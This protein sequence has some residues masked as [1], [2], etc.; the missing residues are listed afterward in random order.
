MNLPSPLSHAGT[1]EKSALWRT[2]YEGL[3]SRYIQLSHDLR[4][5]GRPWDIIELPRSNPSIKDLMAAMRAANAAMEA[6]LHD[7]STPANALHADIERKYRAALAQ[8]RE[9]ANG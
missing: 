3:Q 8:Q 4:S 7:A 5:M 6:A 9:A 1:S 2:T